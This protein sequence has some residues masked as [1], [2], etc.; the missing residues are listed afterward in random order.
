MSP[1]SVRFRIAVPA[2]ALFVIGGAGPDTVFRGSSGAS[3]VSI[4]EEVQEGE[5]W[6]EA[7]A[8]AEEDE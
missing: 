2:I 5:A 7:W 1:D 6:A 3:R 4:V 8:M